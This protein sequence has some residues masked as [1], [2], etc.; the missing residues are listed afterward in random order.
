MY[1]HLKLKYIL[2][3]YKYILYLRHLVRP[4]LPRQ[5]LV[6]DGLVVGADV[7]GLPVLVRALALADRRHLEA[8]CTGQGQ[9]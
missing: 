1:V 9:K 6:V 8:A 2:Y 4:A 7:D 3:T 5:P